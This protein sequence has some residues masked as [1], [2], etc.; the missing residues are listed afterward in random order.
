[1]YGYVYA[2]NGAYFITIVTK[3]REHFFGEI[4]AGEMMLSEIG[5]QVAHN[6]SVI[7]DKISH[8]Q[9]DEWVIMPNH[10]H[11]IVTI[12]NNSNDVG[13]LLY[14]CPVAGTRLL[15]CSCERVSEFLVIKKILPQIG[16]HF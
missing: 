1:M 11:L 8:L 13:T 3:N 2:R 10:L 16:G 6:F 15:A 7:S 5:K 12:E 4:T 9:V 14:I